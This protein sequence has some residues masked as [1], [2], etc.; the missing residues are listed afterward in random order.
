MPESQTTPPTSDTRFLCVHGHFYQPPRENPWLEAIEQQDSAAPFHDWNERITHECYRT[1]ASAR[2]LDAEGWITRI[3]SNYSR[4]S[5]NFGPT[6]L[7]WLEVHAPDVYAA[8]LHA[9]RRSAERFGG[10]GSAIAQCYNHMIMP[11]ASE[12]DRRTQVVW[13]IRDFEHRF[14]RRPEGMWL[15]EA[16][17]DTPTLEILAEHGIAFTILAPRQARRFR[18]I[19]PDG[20]PGPWRDAANE[21]IDPRRAYRCNLPSGRSIALFF[22]DG[23]VSQAVAFERL[24]ESGDRLENRLVSA[25]R[26]QRP[27]DDEPQLVHIATDGETFGH[28][29]RFGE[30]A[31]AYALLRIDARPDIRLT[32][33]ARFLE[34]C[35]PT[36]EA[37][38]IENSSWSCVHGVERWRSDCGCKTGRE[39][40][41][42]QHW[43]APLRDALDF[44]RDRAADLFE[45]SA[46]PLLSDPWAARDAYI[47][48]VLD[49]SDAS[50]DRFLA[51]H[52][53][54][55]LDPDE[56]V[57][58]LRLLEAQRHA[59]LM[60]TSCGWFFDDLSGIETV[61]VILY[62]ARAIQLIS[63]AVGED[64]QEPFLQRLEKAVCNPPDARD[65]RRL[66]TDEVLPSVVD[67]PRLGAHYAVSTLFDELPTSGSIYCYDARQ[68]RLER[69]SAGRTQVRIGRAR[70]R[71][72]ITRKAGDVSFAVVHLGD[73]IIHGG[74]RLDLPDEEY[75]LLASRVDETLANGDIAGLLRVIEE[76]FGT[77]RY[78]LA[79]LFADEQ[80][81]IVGRVLDGAVT[82]LTNA[83]R[84]IHRDTEPLVRFL[85]GHKLPT[86]PVLLLPA[87]QVLN[88]DIAWALADTIP[89]IDAI[90]H[91]LSAARR[92]GVEIDRQQHTYVLERRFAALAARAADRRHR[93]EGTFVQILTELEALTDAAQLMPFPLDLGMAQQAFVELLRVSGGVAHPDVHPEHRA[94]ADRLPRTRIDT[95]AKR[96]KVRF[97]AVPPP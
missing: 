25:F 2:V 12:R 10:H 23:P 78:S 52:Q 35:P 31:L 24:L 13:G 82:R 62:A 71:S 85:A 40:G 73:H 72:R 9:D 18:A 93:H 97:K 59:M 17:V 91:T 55:P 95:L 34:L 6:L 49:R 89:N 3:V 50:V 39:P 86:P 27:G 96:L 67:L 42:T 83:L 70:L 69:L 28:H 5:F 74:A 92:D 14:G 84:D 76:S 29:H 33:Y 1:N 26:P 75:A 64:L 48:A 88:A 43:R 41:G 21:G 8:I 90:R 87:Q 38:I 94:Y 60:Y 56:Q 19:G 81:R 58:A 44:L 7:S 68:I 37:E 66:Y 54:R 51:A 20:R 11:L 47:D 65:G 32:N 53:R 46:A 63:D 80:R 45:R 77:S 30:M 15:P 16:A 22:Y 4:M 79:S 57:R 36:H 61:Q